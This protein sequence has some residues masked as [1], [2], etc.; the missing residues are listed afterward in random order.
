MGM[1]HNG[2]RSINVSTSHDGTIESLRVFFGHHYFLDLQ[3][4]KDGKTE[5]VLD[6]THHGFRADASEVGGHLESLIEEIRSK[7]P[8][9]AVD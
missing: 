4:T 3:R 8:E 7:H 2:I 6:A 9:I 1:D 5:F